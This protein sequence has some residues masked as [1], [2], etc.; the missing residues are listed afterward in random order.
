[1]RSR[2]LRVTLTLLAVV[3]VGAAAWFC[4]TL[5][6][7]ITSI[8]SQAS[9]FVSA[10]LAASRH[11]GDLQAAQQ[12]YVAAGQNEAFWYERVTA[13]GASLRA[14]VLEMEKA[15]GSP[16]ARAEL[17]GLTKLIDEFDRR[18][19]RI[20]SYASAGQKL[21]AADVIF[22]DGIDA[23]A[24]THSTIERAAEAAAEDRAAD[25]RQVAR[26]QALA[27]GGAAAG[28]ILVML[29]LSPLPSARRDETTAVRTESRIDDPLG[30]DLRPPVKPAPARASGPAP[31]VPAGATPQAA[32]ATEAPRPPV[33]P[34]ST[35]APVVELGALAG[36]CTDLARLDDSAVMPSI[37]QRMAKALDAAGLVLW[38]ANADRSELTPIAAHGYPANVLSRM[39]AVPV[40]DENATTA[41]FR[42]GLLQTVSGNGTAN[43]AIAAPLVSPSGCL[44]VISA[45]ISGDGEKAPDRLA[46]ATIVAA[47]LATII[48]PPAARADDRSTAAI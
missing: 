21:L 37:L 18:D 4:W 16:V 26:N 29:L 13:A 34:P 17:A 22:S 5:Q 39:R 8:D 10:R 25:R 40:T 32:K 41:A 30:L 23:S 46:A 45:E 33:A 42:T 38:V 24:Q 20:R 6:T 44:G 14:A 36:V 9:S 35:P 19:Q 28:A 1:M 27:A 12:A 43:G 48:G 2:A 3:G 7:R 11:A 15:T 47:Q 31:R